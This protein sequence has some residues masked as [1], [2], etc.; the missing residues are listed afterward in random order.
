MLPT[1]LA[2]GRRLR[3]RLAAPTGKAAARLTV[4]GEQLQKLPV[5]AAVRDAIP[6]GVTTLHRLLGTRRTAAASGTTATA[7]AR[8]PG[9]GDEAA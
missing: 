3:V 9:G 6:T 8:G 7:R 2:D 5:D 4:I 1:W